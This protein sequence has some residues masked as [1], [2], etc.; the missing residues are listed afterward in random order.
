MDEG[1]TGGGVIRGN[2][3]RSAPD[4][5]GRERELAEIP[6]LLAE[7]R[8]VTLT[9]V[10]GV[11]KTSLALT[12]AA[13]LAADLPDGVWMVDLTSITDPD[14]VPDQI[15][16]TLGI[17]PSGDAGLLESVT[18]T[19][20]DRRMLLLV[21]NCE[22]VLPGAAATVSALLRGAPGLAVLATSRV[23][24]DLPEE[25]RRL[26]MPL[27]VDHDG[28]SGS[29][30]AVAL[31]VE[32]ARALQSR[33][34]FDDE[35][36]A[37]VVLDIC[38]TL[39][40]L[41]L[42][43][44]LAAARSISM[45]PTDLRERLDDRFRLLT[46]APH[47]PQRQQALH[48]VVA[49]SFEVLDEPVR[50]LL[51]HAA[52]F[53][54]GFDVASIAA[55][56]GATDEFGVLDGL[57]TLVRSSLVV[58][59]EVRGSTR[60]SL[61]ETIREFA[62]AELTAAGRVEAVRDRH[63]AHFAALAGAW[64]DR[65]NGPS[66]ND[67]VDW[68]AT[69][70]A[71]LRAA[72]R[73]SRTRGDV[74]TAVDVAAHAGLMGASVQLF[75]AVGWAQD[76]L[77]EARELDPPRLPRLCVAAAWGCFTGHPDRAVAAAQEAR[78]LEARSVE[79][80]GRYDPCEPGLSGLIEALAH[81]Y[82]GHLDRYVGAARGVAA[83]DG[84]PQAWGLSLLLDGLQASGRVDEAIALVGPAMD[85][86]DELGN[87]Y[88]IAYAFWTTGGALANVDPTAALAR[89]TEGLEYVKRHRVDFF[90][91]FI[92]RDAARLR[93][94]DARP[95]DALAMFDAAIEAFQ[96]AGNVPQLTITLASA[97]A[98]FERLG[99]LDRAA[100]LHAAIVGQP[101]SEHHVPELATLG[102]GLRSALPADVLAA[103]VERGQ[104]LDLRDTAE[105]CRSEIQVARDELRDAAPREG[106][107]PGGLSRR[108][109][110]VLQLVA[111]GCTTREMAERLYI[112]AKTAD[113][114]I[115]NLYSKIG[116]SNRAA[117]TR[118]AIEH[119]VAGGPVGP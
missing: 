87:P 24:L 98:L 33:I 56:V 1:T 51:R 86:A 16:T 96:T 83:L 103:A 13:G 58:V 60:Y 95:D 81:V 66:W 73:W 37:A 63:A 31:F 112:S 10:G 74:V 25:H 47:L 67:A 42:A 84:R 80:A 104:R 106:E 110:E 111:A 38:R 70:L 32:R 22:H 57:D 3:A 4:L 113:R 7:H 52:V 49:W 85:A 100:T 89:W 61:L 8:L 105:F 6:G 53:Q 119:D 14:A 114:H 17:V 43:I 5:F 93:L 107:R 88:F 9:G 48:H 46:I 64:W 102:A 28:P 118:W 115:Q 92:A 15:A 75:E 21:D 69:E 62:E 41:P 34:D 23:S 27:E 109:V 18:E 108:E 44:E 26:V 97:A 99:R 12:V 117:A 59:G 71:N 2:V 65:W 68:L 40:G 11:G 45:S 78:S 82:S 36:T 19:L 101:G 91:G 30:P 35:R 29:S 90:V 76:L 50:D 79:E 116:V 20:A 55:V 77:A 39:D 94:D 72:Y 54:D